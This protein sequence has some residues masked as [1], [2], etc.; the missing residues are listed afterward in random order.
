MKSIDVFCRAA[1]LSIW[2]KHRAS[3]RLIHV[4]NRMI[5]HNTTTTVVVKRRD[6]YNSI[7]WSLIFL[8]SSEVAYNG[9][10]GKMPCVSCIV[11][12]Y[13]SHNGPQAETHEPGPPRQPRKRPRPISNPKHQRPTTEERTR[14]PRKGATISHVKKFLA[15]RYTR[16]SVLRIKRQ[17]GVHC[18]CA[19]D[20]SPCGG[21]EVQVHQLQCS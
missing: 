2:L 21:T 4:W 16:E 10:S 8:E 12:H 19:R 9:P 6:V 7:T 15:G 13:F 20:D 5:I 11:S 17:K 14:K 18:Y 3:W 1:S